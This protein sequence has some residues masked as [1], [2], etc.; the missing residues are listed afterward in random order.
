MIASCKVLHC[1]LDDR[2][3]SYM[4]SIVYGS[5]KVC[6]LYL[7]LPCRGG[8]PLSWWL[9]SLMQ[10]I[11]KQR[12]PLFLS[13]APAGDS[14]RK[15]RVR[16]YVE[17]LCIN[18]KRFINDQ[19]FPAFRLLGPGVMDVEV[20]VFGNAKLDL[21]SKTVDCQH[22]PAKCDANVYEQCAVSI[23][24]HPSRYLPFF[25]C[26]FRDLTMGHRDENYGAST[27]A[28]CARESALNFDSIKACH[29]DPD[30]AW[31]LQ[32][33]ASIITPSE[34]DHVPWVTIDG[35]I[36]D[37]SNGDFLQEVCKAYSSSGH[38]HPACKPYW[39]S[40]LRVSVEA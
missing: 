33:N 39:S 11:G 14:P 12:R 21:N 19:L 6:F 38:S 2:D 29:S 18:S 10:A 3:R 35:H 1:L 28:E 8:S 15:V 31:E 22:G 24:H 16:V 25:V 23:F 13:S 40:F 9:S 30:H 32:K 7:Y 34:H 36:F 17:A 4:R 37:D 26:L 5:A 27:F 20:V